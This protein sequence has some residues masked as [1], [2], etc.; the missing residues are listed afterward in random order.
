MTQA[1]LPAPFDW[2]LA[3]AA[4]LAEVFRAAGYRLYLVGGVVRDHLLGLETADQDIDATTDARPAEIR[5]LVADL[6]DAVWTQ[7]E[8]FGTIGCRINGYPY[9]ITT[10]RAE[11]YDE[12]SRKPVVSFGDEIEED[13]ARRD[14][15]VNAMAVDL[16]D[17]RLVDPHDGRGDLQHGV[18]RTPL[19]PV[20]SFS[21]D[22]LRML[23]AARFHA[24][25]GLTPVE[26]LITAIIDIGD[27]MAIVSAER[28]RD[29]LQKL[30]LLD[31]A[32]TGLRLLH[33]TRLLGRVVAALGA[34]D[35]REVEAVSRRVVA[36]TPT[37]G[38]R[39]AALLFNVDSLHEALG[40]LKPSGALSREVA[41]LVGDRS[42][43]EVVPTDDRSLRREAAATSG[44]HVLEERLDFVEALRHADGGEAVDINAARK[45]IAALRVAEPDL[46]NPGAVLSG[47]QVCALLELHPGP[48]VGTALDWL[49]EQ[50]FAKG[51]LDPSDARER[52]AAWWSSRPS[53]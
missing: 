20:V 37:I 6:A 1:P 22:P 41:W 40:S 3:E 45:A 39:W 10:H 7:G 49:A 19:D 53:D 16:G 18:L 48:Q 38:P 13:L 47:G 8:R 50:R 25:Y 29:E 33:D 23:R 35:T 46:D 15:T 42:W 34:L 17:H 14:F 51:P 36:Q 12:A 9:E 30:L 32:G 4:P 11:A 27:R 2:V 5:R 44:G 43:L 52:L 24:A 31:R 28:I 21:D 26:P